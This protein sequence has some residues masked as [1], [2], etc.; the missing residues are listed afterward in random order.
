MEAS[1]RCTLRSRRSLQTCNCRN[2]TLQSP[3]SAYRHKQIFTCTCIVVYQGKCS[4]T[5]NY[6]HVDIHVTQ[7]FSPC[8]KGS[9]YWTLEIW[10]LHVDAYP[11][12]G[13]CPG[14]YDIYMFIYCIA[15]NF[16]LEKELCLFFC[17]LL[18]W[19][20]FSGIKFSLTVKITIGS[21]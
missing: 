10:Y 16:C 7:Y 5:L 12:V 20:K 4:W 9:V 1:F 6:L 14:H 8:F 18:L 19:A 11:G 21:V 13:A 15:R 3:C 17:Q 2:S